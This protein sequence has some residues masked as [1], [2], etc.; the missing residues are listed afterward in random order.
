MLLMGYFDSQYFARVSSESAIPVEP[1]S[2][3]LLENSLFR[4]YFLTRLHRKHGLVVI[5]RLEI[6]V[7]TLV[8]LYRTCESIPHFMV[9]ILLYLSK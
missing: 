2:S 8:V 3:K 7:D 9:H 1:D 5:L 6:I 4:S